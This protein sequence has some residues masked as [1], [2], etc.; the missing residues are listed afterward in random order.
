MS[1]IENPA[2]YFVCRFDG[3]NATAVYLG[4]LP[5]LKNVTSQLKWR[6]EK[7]FEAEGI[8][9][10]YEV[11][12]LD[13]IREQLQRE[14]ITIIVNGPFSGVIVQYGNY[15]DSWYEIGTTARF[16]QPC[17]MLRSRLNGQS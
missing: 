2:D 5:N 13:E 16:R 1:K 8:E 4:T 6:T 12:T 17:L 10:S 14:M 7:P 11:L 15:G 9:D 3:V